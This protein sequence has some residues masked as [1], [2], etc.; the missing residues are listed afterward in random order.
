MNIWRGHM[1]RFSCDWNGSSCCSYWSIHGQEGNLSLHND[2]H[3][4]LKQEH[5]SSWL[6]FCVCGEALRT[7]TVQNR[8]VT[9]KDGEPRCWV[10]ERGLTGFYKSTRVLGMNSGTCE[11]SLFKAALKYPKQVWNFGLWWSITAQ[12]NQT[13]THGNCKCIN[14]RLSWLYVIMEYQNDWC[15]NGSQ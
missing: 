12:A 4:H 1:K 2:T 3:T 6:R 7:D 9:W 13:S 14:M 10:M 15:L 5:S 11:L 8:T